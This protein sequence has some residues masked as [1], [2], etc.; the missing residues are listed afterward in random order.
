MPE[1]SRIARVEIGTPDVPYEQSADPHEAD[2]DGAGESVPPDSV[3]KY[4]TL[5]EN[6]ERLNEVLDGATQEQKEFELDDELD[7]E[8]P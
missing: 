1:G 2:E 6:E 4:F 8:V 5:D 7:A 3:V